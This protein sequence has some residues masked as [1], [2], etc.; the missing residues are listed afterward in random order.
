MRHGWRGVNEKALAATPNFPLDVVLSMTY[1]ASNA[2]AV[3]KITL[4]TRCYIRDPSCVGTFSNKIK[5]C[6]GV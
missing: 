4:E 5:H 1:L 2:V 3:P 6:V